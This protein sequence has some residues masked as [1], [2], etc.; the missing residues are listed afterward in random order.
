MSSSVDHRPY[1]LSM[2]CTRGTQSSSQASISY[3]PQATGRG[4]GAGNSRVWNPYLY[5]VCIQAQVP[6]LPVRGA[7]AHALALY[8]KAIPGRVGKEAR[9][10]VARHPGVP[11]LEQSNCWARYRA[12][13][14][15]QGPLG[16]LTRNVHP[17]EERRREWEEVWEVAERG[18]QGGSWCAGACWGSRRL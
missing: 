16:N 13:P 4:P 8:F 10:P 12:R 6:R 9:A 2:R 5:T 17:C 7:P 14:A 18:E 3:G 11:G 15:S 1:L